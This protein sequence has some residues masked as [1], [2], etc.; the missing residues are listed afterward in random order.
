[1]DMKTF[2]TI[3][4]VVGIAYT[5]RDFI[6]DKINFIL[7]KDRDTQ[8]E[9][10][11]HRKIGNNRPLS[12][13]Y[14]D[15]SFYLDS[16]AR[17]FAEYG[18]TTNEFGAFTRLLRKLEK[19]TYVK[20]LEFILTNCKN[21]KELVDY[22]STFK[23]SPVQVNFVNVKLGN[24]ISSEELN[25]ML[26]ENGIDPNNC[27]TPN[28]KVKA[29]LNLYQGKGVEKLGKKFGERIKELIEL[30]TKQIPCEISFNEIIQEIEVEYELN[31]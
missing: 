25:K 18:I 31:K 19:A 16:M 24:C 26:I 12:P 13:E 7:G 20:Y 10:L 4:A 22:V 1:M 11:K 30:Q 17:L 9:P 2:I 3:A 23:I 27:N 6:Y 29:L 21:S 28:D 15:N 14:K 8:D 5:F